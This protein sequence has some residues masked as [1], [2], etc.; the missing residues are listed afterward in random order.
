MTAE[1][2]GF[3]VAMHGVRGGKAG[4][5]ALFKVEMAPKDGQFVIAN[6]RGARGG[7]LVTSLRRLAGERKKGAKK[8]GRGLEAAPAEAPGGMGPGRASLVWHVDRR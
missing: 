7:D 5:E 1:G 3:L 8:Q 2:K 6:V 4:S